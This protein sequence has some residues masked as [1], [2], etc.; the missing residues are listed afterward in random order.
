MRFL[1]ARE[2]CYDRPDEALRERGA[3]DVR[4]LGAACR[5]RRPRRR[6]D[7]RLSIRRLAAWLLAAFLCSAYAPM[8][9]EWTVSRQEFEGWLGRW[10]TSRLTVKRCLQYEPLIERWNPDFGLPENVVLAVMAKESA[11]L[12]NAHDGTSVGLMAV[13][14]RSW[15]FSEAELRSP[16]TNVY[17]GMFIL[18][19]ALKKADGDMALALAAYNCG[20]ESLAA[21]KCIAG[22]GHDYTASVLTYW[23]PIVEERR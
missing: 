11:C 6:L 1:C 12:A 16:A 20:W 8:E 2:N 23:L 10:V 4:V 14:P 9:P 7:P 5:I 22:G 15:L 21:G 3:A 19:G 18:S 13:T 17:A